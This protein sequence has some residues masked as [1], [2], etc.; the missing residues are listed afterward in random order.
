MAYGRFGAT[1]ARPTRADVV[2]RIVGEAGLLPT[3]RTHQEYLPI[4][5]QIGYEGD[6]LAVR[7][8][9]RLVVPYLV[10]CQTLLAGRVYIHLIYLC[11]AADP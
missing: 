10:F 8:P 6:L 2:A 7:R 4:A 11:V 5:V 3:I 1:L 9:D